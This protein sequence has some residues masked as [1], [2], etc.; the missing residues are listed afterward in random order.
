MMSWQEQLTQVKGDMKKPGEG[1]DSQLHLPVQPM[2]AV[3][4]R[5]QTPQDA[6]DVS[7]G[8][9]TVKSPSGEVVVPL[10]DS[11]QNEFVEK[12][13]RYQQAII[14]EKRANVFASCA[15]A[16]LSGLSAVAI[17]FTLIRGFSSKRSNTIIDV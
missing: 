7:G 2:K 10:S 15:M 14:N 12:A 1:D 4:Q 6:V 8:R 17:G 16:A 11:A 3:P 13:L 9:M 5:P